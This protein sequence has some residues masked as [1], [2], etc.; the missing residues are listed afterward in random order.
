MGFYTLYSQNLLPRLL[1]R[2]MQGP[3]FDRYRHELL[4]AV[5]GRVLEIGFGTGLNLPHYPGDRLTEL[6]AIDANPGMSRL[7]Q[8]RL[9]HA[10]FPI[11]HRVLNGEQL[12]LPD[13][14]FDAVVSTWTLCSIQQVEQAIAEIKRVLKPGGQF[15][16]IEHG[17]SDRPEVQRWQRRL[18]PLQ[19][20][21]GDGCHLDRPIHDL[22]AQQF[23]QVEVRSFPAPDVPEIGGYF[24]Q[25]VA[26][27]LAQP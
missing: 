20:V 22:V 3:M 15:W 11:E 8:H 18:T 24:Y 4:Q 1:D 9:H 19:K 12:P 27:K 5:Q 25:G 7:A 23:A 16:F 14:S 6:V 17:L 10:S 21:L 2:V 13:A 26:T